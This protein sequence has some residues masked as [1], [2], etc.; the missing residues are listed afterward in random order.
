MAAIK[1][2]ALS[3]LGLA[4]E[5]TLGTPVAPTAF[6]PVRSFKPQDDPKYVANTGMQGQPVSLFG[7][8]EGVISSNYDIEGDVFPTSFGTLLANIF[9]SDTVSGT[10]APYTHTLGTAATPGSLTLS[11]Y[12]VANFR[13]FPGNKV[14]K[15]VVKYSADSA[16]TYTASLIGFPSVTGTAPAS[17]T[18]STLPFFIG[19]EAQMKIG[20]TVNPRL[21]SATITFER[22]GTEAVFAANN[23]Q[24]PF[25]TFAG[26]FSVTWQL[27]FFMLDDTEYNL[28]LTQGVQPVTVTFTQGGSGD[29]LTFTSSAVQFTKPTIDRSGKFVAVSLDGSAVYNATDASVGTAT[30]TNAVSTSYATT[31]SS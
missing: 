23:S 10:T 28:A 6:I 18:F 31:A 7:E 21:R 13:Q 5:T 16:L 27:N 15:L 3:Y 4:V 12:Y 8:Y 19:Y 1:L 29:T 9:G 20:G 30:M 22:Q 2:S 24:T 25:D 11:D 26:A 17:K 14:S